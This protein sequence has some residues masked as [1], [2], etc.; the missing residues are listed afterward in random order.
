[1]SNAAPT[2]AQIQVFEQLSGQLGE[3]MDQYRSTKEIDLKALNDELIRREIQP[4][5]IVN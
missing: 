4:I 5:E 2:K 3:L 1:L